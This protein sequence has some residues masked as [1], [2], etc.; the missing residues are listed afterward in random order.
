[1]NGNLVRESTFYHDYFAFEAIYKYDQRNL[2]VETDQKGIDW[3]NVM[4]YFEY[5]SFD[6]KGNWTMVIRLTPDHKPGGI[7]I[8]DIQY[9][10]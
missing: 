1:M 8:R 9:A 5:Q 10:D 3:H 7:S 2:E 6:D 4:Y